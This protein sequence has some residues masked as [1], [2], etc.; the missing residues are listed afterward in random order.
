M[1][2]LLEL[3]EVHSGYPT[4]PVLRGVN[5][6]LAAGE[7]VA[8]IGAN[9]AGKT[10]LLH[11]LVGLVRPTAGEVIAF[12]QVRRSETDFHA[13]R[14]QVGLVFQDADDQLFCPTVLEDV[15]FG[16]R[17]L[18]RTSA[19]AKADALD[20]LAA[21]GLAG[22]A[23]RVTYRLSAGEKRLVALATV[24]A[25]KPT[26]LLLDEPTNGLDAA[27]EARLIQYL[28]ALKQAMVIVSHDQQVLAQLATRSVRLDSGVL[29]HEP[30]MNS[31]KHP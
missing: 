15:A 8:L 13:V 24:L 6:A 27:T 5:F 4:H 3:R 31:A 2:S 9:G 17:N 14:A 10:T 7:R 26:V 22:F 11:L 19:Q 1:P 18:G 20:T 25:M 21:L 30:R 16:P 29:H 28:A 12:G 23:E